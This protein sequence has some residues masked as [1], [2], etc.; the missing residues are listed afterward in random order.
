[1]VSVTDLKNIWEETQITL[2]KA[3]LESFL[4]VVF[5]M[6]LFV[7]VFSKATTLRNCEK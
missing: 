1:M 6:F 4:V 7:G 2:T 3:V 5:N